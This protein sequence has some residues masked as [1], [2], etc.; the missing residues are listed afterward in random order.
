MKAKSK[1]AQVRIK[2]ALNELTAAGN[3]INIGCFILEDLIRSAMDSLEEEIK[4]AER[5]KQR[6]QMIPLS[7]YKET[8]FILKKHI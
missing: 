8:L 2:R 5:K 6:N 7:C 1:K 3:H 4:E